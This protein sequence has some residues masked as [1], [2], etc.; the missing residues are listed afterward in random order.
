MYRCLTKHGTV[1]YTKQVV[2]DLE[3][4]LGVWLSDD[5]QPDQCKVEESEL[6]GSIGLELFKDKN[7]KACTE[8]GSAN[9]ILKAVPHCI[10]RHNGTIHARPYI[11]THARE[12]DGVTVQEALSAKYLNE[13]RYT[14]ADLRYD[15][16]CGWLVLDVHAD[17]QEGEEDDDASNDPSAAGPSKRGA[18]CGQV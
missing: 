5:M 9:A 7:G 12:R 15:L 11:Y 10:H 8:F 4:P 16:K 17:A 2:W 3:A 1:I 14:V 18:A 6:Y 13:V